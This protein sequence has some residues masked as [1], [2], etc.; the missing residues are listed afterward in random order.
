MADPVEV[1]D[2]W[3]GELGPDAWYAGG[4]A[5]DGLCRE[6]FLD[7]WQAAS[8]GMIFLNGLGAIGGPVVAG[9]LMAEVGAGGFFLLMAILFG[10]LALYALWRMTRRASAPSAGGF[11]PLSPSASAVAVEAVVDRADPRT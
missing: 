5:I 8:A 10:L 2:F 1:L 7:L 6:R 4:E 9:W 3:L 11:A